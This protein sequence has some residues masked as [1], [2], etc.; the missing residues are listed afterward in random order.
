MKYPIPLLAIIALFGFQKKKPEYI[1]IPQKAPLAQQQNHD[2][3]E[4]M[5]KHCYICHGP[6]A[7]EDNGRIAPPMVAIKARYIDKGGYNKIEFIK[8]V[9]DFVKNPTKEK[10]LMRGAVN[11][12]GLMP[13]QDF[14]K[15]SVE[16]IAQFM[17]DYQIEEPVWFKSHWESHGNPNWMQ[18][19]QKYTDV[20]IKKNYSDIGLEYALETKK[21]LGKNLMGTIQKKGTIAALDFCNV[22][23]MPLTDSMAVKYNATIKR[24]SDKNRNS[25]NTANAAELKIIEQFKTQLAKKEELKATMENGVFYAPITTNNMCLQCHGSEKDIKPETL[26]KIKSLYPHDK[27]IGYQENEMRGLMVIKPN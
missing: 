16:K 24:V 5:E 2:G 26:A 17:F 6:S 1:E 10:A 21:V 7:S 20:V 8:H 9:T 11:K 18:S 23:A 13:K 4:L 25:D 12:H 14:P 15:G 19:G 22:Q 3:K 27:A